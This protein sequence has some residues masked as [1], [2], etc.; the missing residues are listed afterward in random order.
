MHFHND[1]YHYNRFQY[2]SHNNNVYPIYYV[3][4][5]KRNVIIITRYEN[6]ILL[7]GLNPT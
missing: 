7:G 2:L 1:I 3:V 6:G 4:T 5:A